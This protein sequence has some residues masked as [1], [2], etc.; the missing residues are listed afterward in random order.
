MARNA[1]VDVVRHSESSS[2]KASELAEYFVRMRLFLGLIGGIS[3]G[4]F[5]HQGGT[6]LAAGIGLLYIV[7]IWYAK[8]IF[9]A[10]FNSKRPN[11]IKMT[12]T[13]NAIALMALVWIAFY[14]WSNQGLLLEMQQQLQGPSSTSD[15]IGDFSSSKL[16]SDGTRNSQAH[17]EEMNR[18]IEL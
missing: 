14:T 8:I 5:H 12:G 16:S 10:D 3:L 2:A 17:V 15:S 9:D 6:G 11:S 4:V 18:L 13:L 1:N 7:P